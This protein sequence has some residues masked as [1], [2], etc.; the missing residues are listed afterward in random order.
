MYSE[1]E[2]QDMTKEELIRKFID[3]QNDYDNLD[4]DY[5]D[6]EKDNWDLQSDIDTLQGEILSLKSGILDIDLFKEK[7]ELYGFKTK[8]LWNFLDLYMKL[9]NKEW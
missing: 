3:L 4:E 9:Y 2:L 7:L 8:E 1:K 6:L 5:G